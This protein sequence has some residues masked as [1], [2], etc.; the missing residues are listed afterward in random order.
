MIEHLDAIEKRYNDISEELTKP[1][2][3]SDIKENNSI[4]KRVT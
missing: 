4:I 3:L 2:V 1:E